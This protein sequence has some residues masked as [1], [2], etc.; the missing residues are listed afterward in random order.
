MAYSPAA[1][2]AHISPSPQAQTL[3]LP[4]VPGTLGILVTQKGGRHTAKPRRF[5]GGPAA[6]LAWCLANRAGLVLH[7]GAAQPV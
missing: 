2:L 3:F 4:A 1:S 7:W 6:A 5:R